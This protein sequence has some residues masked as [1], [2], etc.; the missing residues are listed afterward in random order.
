MCILSPAS[1]QNTAP[2]IKDFRKIM[3][4]ISP[5][6]KG[7]INAMRWPDR[8]SFEYPILSPKK[9]KKLCFFKKMLTRNDLVSNVVIE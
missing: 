3:E 8:F 6:S 4:M 7:K 1:A 2:F 5:A 9:K